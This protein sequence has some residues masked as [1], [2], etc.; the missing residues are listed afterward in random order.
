MWKISCSHTDRPTA[1]DDIIQRIR[2][3]CWITKI[4]DTNSKYV[5]LNR[6][7][8]ETVVTR[9]RLKIT[10]YLHCL[11]CLP[12]SLQGL[13]WVWTRCCMV[14]GRGLTARVMVRPKHRYTYICSVAVFAFQQKGFRAFWVFFFP[15]SNRPPPCDIKKICVQ[16]LRDIRQC[17]ICGN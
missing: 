10:L 16:S 2:F 9:T 14:R 15:G 6:F 17:L 7:T 13:S 4:T 11:Y 12:L 5:I 1:G 8:T 3:A